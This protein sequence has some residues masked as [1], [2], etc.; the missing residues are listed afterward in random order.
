M[1]GPLIEQL[2][3]GKLRSTMARIRDTAWTGRMTLAAAEKLRCAVSLGSQTRY[4][5]LPSY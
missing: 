1:I 2:T 5:V 4:T 3:F